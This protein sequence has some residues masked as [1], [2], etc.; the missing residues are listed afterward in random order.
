MIFAEQ[1]KPK[2][3]VLTFTAFY[4]EPTV[5]FLEVAL[6]ILD[7]NL[8]FCKIEKKISDRAFFDPTS[9]SLPV[10]R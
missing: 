5:N 4:K 3:R 7:Y 2:I 6:I 10:N 9:G 1:D 8:V